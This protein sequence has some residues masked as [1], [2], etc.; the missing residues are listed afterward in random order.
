MAWRLPSART[1]GVG[2]RRVDAS[3]RAP[4]EV[5][6]ALEDRARDRR[7]RLDTESAPLDGRGHDDLRIAVGSDH[8]VPGLILLTV[9]LGGT[10]LAR[11]RDGEAAHDRIGGAAG[12]VGGP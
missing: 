2:G 8:A 10:G 9:A 3:G 6:V 12:L 1:C 11:D 7:R 5:E 4:V